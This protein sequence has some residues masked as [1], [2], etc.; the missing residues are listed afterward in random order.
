[1]NGVLR[2]VERLLHPEEEEARG[3]FALGAHD[4]PSMYKHIRVLEMARGGLQEDDDNWESY[5]DDFGME[6]CL[7]ITAYGKT[8][9]YS[10]WFETK[11]SAQRFLDGVSA[12]VKPDTNPTVFAELV[13]GFMLLQ[14][15]TDVVTIV[16]SVWR[17]G[18]RA[19]AEAI[20][21]VFLADSVPGAQPPVI[22]QAADDWV[23]MLV[24]PA[25]PDHK[26]QEVFVL[27]HLPSDD[28][29]YLT[30]AI[31][32]PQ[33]RIEDPYTRIRRI[34]DA[35]S[36]EYAPPWSRL[37]PD[38][39]PTCRLLYRSPQRV[40]FPDR[41]HYGRGVTSVQYMR[42]DAEQWDE[43]DAIALKAL[44]K[45][46]ADPIVVGLGFHAVKRLQKNRLRID[47]DGFYPPVYTEHHWHVVWP[48]WYQR[49][50]RD[51]LN[52]WRFFR[53]LIHIAYP[54]R[55]VRG[56]KVGRRGLRYEF[57]LWRESEGDAVLIGPI[58]ECVVGRAHIQIRI[59]D[60]T[61]ADASGEDTEEGEPDQGLEDWWDGPPEFA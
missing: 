15:S 4:G 26:A 44:F 37:V 42:L 22:T 40:Y 24:S 3:R 53:D 47:A 57:G 18:R 19:A 38:A 39:G 7:V 48:V 17:N 51:S 13:A 2:R 32:G 60:R 14:G 10:T 55:A 46:N 27:W 61:M 8:A 16:G 59:A 21:S 54:S 28:R 43:E 31:A 45:P 1:M 29:A 5:V 20:A 41:A 56:K 6:I 52:M 35:T 9:R 23:R 50:I 49:H 33:H 25:S 36:P 34:V 11:E 12:Q 30:M 58:F